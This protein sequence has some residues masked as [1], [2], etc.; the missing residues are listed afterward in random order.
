MKLN[1]ISADDYRKQQEREGVAEEQRLASNVISERTI[2]ELECKEYHVTDAESGERVGSIY[3]P[4]E[5]CE[6][7]SCEYA[8]GFEHP[9]GF[10][11]V[12]GLMVHHACGRPTRKWW[13][14]NFSEFVT[15]EEGVT[16]PWQT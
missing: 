10:I 3:A 2:V 6:P 4:L 11:T 16:L 5:F 9:M 1:K 15:V 14:R 12:D 8:V 13:A 7:V